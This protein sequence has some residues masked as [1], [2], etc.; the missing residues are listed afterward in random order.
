MTKSEDAKKLLRMKEQI[1]Q[2]QIKTARLQ[3]EIDSKYNELKTVFNCSNLAE[4]ERSLATMDKTLNKDVAA[5]EA[6][7]DKLEAAYQWES[8]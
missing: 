2:A 5:F 6:A 8:A 7:M 3:G 4:A 1:E